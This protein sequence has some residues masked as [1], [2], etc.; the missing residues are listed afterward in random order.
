MYNKHTSKKIIHVTIL[1]IQINYFYKNDKNK[2][3]TKVVPTKGRCGQSMVVKMGMGRHY[4]NHTYTY[5][6][7][8]QGRR[9]KVHMKFAAL[10]WLGNNYYLRSRISVLL[11]F[12]LRQSFNILINFNS[13]LNKYHYRRTMGFCWK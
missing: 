11:G 2:R 9:K 7:A 13:S 5:V 3:L 1:I 8:H 10:S 6:K 4:V 12:I